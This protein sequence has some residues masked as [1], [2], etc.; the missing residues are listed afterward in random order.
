[1]GANAAI[2]GGTLGFSHDELSLRDFGEL[3][4]WGAGTAVGEEEIKS[5]ELSTEFSE[6]EKMADVGLSVTELA[7]VLV[8]SPAAA[9]AAAAAAAFPA[10]RRL[11]MKD[12]A[13]AWISVDIGDIPAAAAAAAAAVAVVLLALCRLLLVLTTHFR[14]CFSKVDGTLKGIP[15]YRHL[16]ISLPTRPCVFICRVNLED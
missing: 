3:R 16:N 15:Q 5:L 7:A 11:V 8:L 1:V 14:M 6:P 9:A 4:S 12:V 2:E 10:E 13:E